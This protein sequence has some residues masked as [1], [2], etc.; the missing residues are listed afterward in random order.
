VAAVAAEE[1]TR[2]PTLLA[3]LEPPEDLELGDGAAEA[4]AEVI[5]AAG[6]EEATNRSTSKQ[7]N[8]S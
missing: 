7:K 2:I 6:G 4:E 3:V 8:Q 1:E 5:E